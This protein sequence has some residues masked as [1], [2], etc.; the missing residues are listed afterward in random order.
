MNN[1]FLL[2]H[3]GV[4]QSEEG[5]SF[6]YADVKHKL[7]LRYARFRKGDVSALVS[8]KHSKEKLK[9]LLAKPKDLWIFHCCGFK[10]L[11]S[12]F[13]RWEMREV[14]GS[15]YQYS[16][17]KRNWKD[18]ILGDDEKI[19]K[20]FEIHQRDKQ[21]CENW[22]NKVD[23]ELIFKP[24]FEIRDITSIYRADVFNLAADFGSGTGEKSF[25][26]NYLRKLAFFNKFKNLH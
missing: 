16:N 3:D 18:Y 26:E 4:R 20:I 22:T 14:K 11:D 17:D 7:Y 9:K 6:Y 25:P 24:H 19:D 10:V 2:Y 12:Y 21:E 13:N 15:H 8:S 1:Y 5:V 23:Y